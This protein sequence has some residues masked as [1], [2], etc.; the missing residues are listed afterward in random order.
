MGTGT[1]KRIWKDKET[2]K[3]TNF[4][5]GEEYWPTNLVYDSETGIV[6]YRFSEVVAF[7]KRGGANDAPAENKVGFMAPYLNSKGKPCRFTES[8][9]IVEA[10]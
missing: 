4:K 5:A 10:Q 8:F 3:L 1:L 6:Y 9:K 2:G 7:T